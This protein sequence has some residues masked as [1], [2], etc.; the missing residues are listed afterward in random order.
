LPKRA[1]RLGVSVPKLAEN[2]EA[3]YPHV[4]ILSKSSDKVK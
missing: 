3:D 1:L 4:D 2:L